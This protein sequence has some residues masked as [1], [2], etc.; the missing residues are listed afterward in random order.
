MTNRRQK[1]AF[2][3]SVYKVVVMLIFL[4]NTF[5]IRTVFK[6]GRKG[7]SNVHV[8]GIFLSQAQLNSE[9]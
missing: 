9:I 5:S 2:V 3:Q 8:V 1:I 7:V 4:V 6:N